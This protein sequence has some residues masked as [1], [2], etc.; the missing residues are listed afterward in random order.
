MCIHTKSSEHFILIIC[1]LFV[2][3][4]EVGDWKNCFTVAQ[5]EA[6][7]SLIQ[8]KFAGSDLTFMT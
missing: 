7:E 1:A 2:I 8:E 6:M 3:A 5:N 4:G